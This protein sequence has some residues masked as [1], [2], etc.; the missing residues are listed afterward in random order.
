[1]QLWQ[2]KPILRSP[3]SY[4]PAVNT[5]R[6]LEGKKRILLVGDAGGREWKVLTSLGKE[7]HVVDL[8]PQTD[9][10]NLIVQ[11]IERRTPFPDAYFDGVVMNEVLEHLFHDVDALREV[12]RIL[13]DDGILVI[14]V[15][16]FS[17]AQDEAEYHV[18]VHTPKTIRRLLSNCG[19]EI[20]EH[21]CR[22]FSTR[23]AQKSI[24]L[25]AFIYAGHKAAERLFKQSPEAS[26]HAVNGP[27]E[28]LERFLGG[29]LKGFLHRTAELCRQKRELRKIFMMFSDLIS[30]VLPPYTRSP[31]Q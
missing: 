17:N 3:D 25:R 22:G 13:N 28:K 12:R 15:P 7:V 29:H 16:Y 1:M 2:D 6:F 9:I 10:P 14:T 27:L 11:S 31:F 26:V 19:F 23:A 5:V 24:L 8:A 20:Q 4:I 18:R 21:F 30:Q